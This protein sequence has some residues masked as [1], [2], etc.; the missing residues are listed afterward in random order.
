MIKIGDKVKFLNAV[1]GGVV[2]GFSGKNMVM[3]EDEMGFEIPTLIS[4][5]VLVD[6]K[7]DNTDA[8][9]KQPTDKQ[10]VI[11]NGEELGDTEEIVVEDSNMPKFYFA[12]VPEDES[13]LISGEIKTYLVNVSNFTLLFNYSH[14]SDGNYLSVKSGKLEAGTKIFLESFSPNELNNLPDFYFQLIFFQQQSKAYELP[15]YKR[16][17]VNPVKFYKGKS[18]RQTV[19]FPGISM[20]IPINNS[21]FEDE[22]QDLTSQEIRKAIRE[23]QGAKEKKQII[24]NPDLVEVDLHIHELLDDTRGLSNHEMLEIQMKTFREKLEEAQKN[25][26]KRIVFIHGLGNGT[27]KQ[28]IRKELSQRFKKYA[29]QDAS[30]QEYGFGATMVIMKR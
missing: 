9:Q 28:E 3:V 29:F 14:Y 11:L 10:S 15:L 18:F 24:Q 27:L 2:T 13:N 21:D 20:L 17:K 6:E 1:G 25:G 22:L 5:L 30:F 4:Q 8:G 23:K 16:I 7:P 12:F 26:N 19:Y